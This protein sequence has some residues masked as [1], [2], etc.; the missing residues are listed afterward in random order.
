MS[1]QLWVVPDDDVPV[2][3][4]LPEL[5]VDVVVVDCAKVATETNAATA[6]I[7]SKATMIMFFFVGWNQLPELDVVAIDVSCFT[8]LYIIFR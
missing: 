1:G 5:V 7:A 4:E 8:S 2:L 6:S 3:L